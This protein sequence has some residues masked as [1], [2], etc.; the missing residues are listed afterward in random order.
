METDKLQ[1]RAFC[2]SPK[3]VVK[4]LPAYHCY[5]AKSNGHLS[6]LILPDFWT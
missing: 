1:I 2:P 4:H 5:V 6:V 3:P